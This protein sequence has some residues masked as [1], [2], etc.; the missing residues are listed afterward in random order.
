MNTIPN[1]GF[2]LSGTLNRNAF[3]VV[4]LDAESD[5]L[6]YWLTQAPQERLRHIQRLRQINHGHRASE[7]LQRIFEVVE[8]TQDR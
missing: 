7:R 8:F 5:E 2:A 1:N 6:S 3:S 4:S